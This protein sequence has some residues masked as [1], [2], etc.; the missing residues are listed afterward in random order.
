MIHNGKEHLS[1]SVEWVSKEKGDGAGFDILSK[2][3]NGTDRYIEVKSTKLGERVPIYF[4][5]NELYFSREHASN[6]FLY[7]V[8]N[9]R[10][11]PRFFIKNGAIDSSW[12]I[13]PVSFI[14]RI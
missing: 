4:T 10:K 8:F 14:G 2:N 7:R 13:E 6:Y 11:E 3:L 1:E 5:R 9:L 12:N